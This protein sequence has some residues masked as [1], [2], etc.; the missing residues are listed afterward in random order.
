[1]RDNGRIKLG[2]VG[3]GAIA[4][5]A[6]IPAA[7]SSSRVEIKALSD[8]DG[9]R[10]YHLHRRFGLKECGYLD[11]RET[12]PHVEAVVLAVPNYLHKPVGLDFLSR[13]IH[14][15]CEKPLACCVVDCRQMFQVAEKAG[16]VLAVG[17]VTRF[18][19]STELTKEL[20]TSNLL[21]PL[22]SFDYEFGAAG[23]WEPIS[24]YN[25]YRQS[26]GGGV[27]MV[28]GS[29]FVDRMMH[30]FSDVEVTR[31]LH[32]GRGG[33]EANC[34]IWL[35]CK[36]DARW[37][38]G[39]ITLSK[40]HK[41]KNR[42]CFVGHRGRIEIRE[43]QSESV[44]YYPADSELRHEISCRSG[45][46]EGSKDY[47]RVQL[48]NFIDAVRKGTKPKVDGESATKSV[49]LIE[50]CYEIAEPLPESWSDATLPSLR[51]A[52]PA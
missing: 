7:L 41:L 52:L 21:G 17:Y 37:V 36:L 10:L 29:H 12:Y 11:Y 4:E 44:T 42:L 19:P 34:I 33:V 8:P 15:L 35:K 16:A 46:A 3:C 28:S 51:S 47:F 45:E 14:V 1:M 49:A 20:I 43:S 27:L 25:L 13:G 30:F 18:Y 2:I 31:C 24:G 6:H 38:E 5:A 22:L 40:T 39:R 48:E 26:A 50:K 32:D 9:R 23:G